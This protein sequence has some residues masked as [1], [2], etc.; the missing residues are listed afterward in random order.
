MAWADF[1]TRVSR[2]RMKWAR[3]RCQGAP[4]VEARVD[5]AVVG[6]RDHKGGAG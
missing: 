2:L 4:R 3:Q 5:Q 6:V 1:G